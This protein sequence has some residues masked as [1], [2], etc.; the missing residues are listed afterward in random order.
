M[1]FPSISYAKYVDLENFE[2]NV[3]KW[4]K[5]IEE[6]QRIDFNTIIELMRNHHKSD[7]WFSSLIG[8][9][10]QHG[11]GGCVINED[12]A[13]ES[14]LLAVKIEI[15]EGLNHFNDDLKEINIIIGKYLLA[16]YY[17][18]EIIEKY[19]AKYELFVG[20]E[21]EIEWKIDLCSN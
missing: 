17:Y 9:F 3:T 7:S 13:L 1:K 15:E 19:I 8:F 4:V 5:L 11:I 10:Y 6:S 21:I 18:K 16:L 20:P 14:Y 2:N 12:K